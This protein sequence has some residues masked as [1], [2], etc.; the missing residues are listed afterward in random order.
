MN[1]RKDRF[2][3]VVA[4][5]FF[6][7]AASSFLLRHKDK[8]LLETA[9]QEAA[10]LKA[11]IELRDKTIAE[12]Q[13]RDDQLQSSGHISSAVSFPSSSDALAELMRLKSF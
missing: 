3:F 1:P 5:L 10:Q 4:A 12:L 11:D 7:I 6:V 9:R 13:A 2:W 8:A